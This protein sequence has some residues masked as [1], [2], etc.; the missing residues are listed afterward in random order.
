M[1]FTAAVIVV[2]HKACFSTACLWEIYGN[3]CIKEWLGKPMLDFQYYKTSQFEQKGYFCV[4][5]WWVLPTVF[6]SDSI[7]N[8]RTSIKIHKVLNACLNL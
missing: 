4:D 5:V 6:L 3:S 2:V 1:I 8:S 7:I